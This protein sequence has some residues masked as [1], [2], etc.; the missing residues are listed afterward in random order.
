M[1]A[2]GKK[3][4]E[5]LDKLIFNKLLIYRLNYILIN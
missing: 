1:Y 2:L 4:K 5:Y 3:N